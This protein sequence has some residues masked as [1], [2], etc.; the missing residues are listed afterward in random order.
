MPQPISLEQKKELK[1]LG[2]RA[3]QIRKAQGLTL[4]Q[5]ARKIDKDRQSIH[6]F[7]IGDFNPSYIYILEVCKGLGIRINELLERK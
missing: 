2:A 5:V 1:K 6:R 4:E 7:E 3:K